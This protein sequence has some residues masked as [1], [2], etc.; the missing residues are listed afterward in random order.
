MHVFYS[1]SS[2]E[3]EKEKLLRYSNVFLT[4]FILCNLFSFNADNRTSV[5]FYIGVYYV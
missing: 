3:Y 5:Q 1:D 4:K 2:L